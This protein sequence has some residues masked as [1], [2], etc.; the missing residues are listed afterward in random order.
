MN[1]KRRNEIEKMKADLATIKVATELLAG[2]VQDAKDAL[3]AIKDAEQDAYDNMP[4]GLQQGDRGQACEVAVSAL[5]NVVGTLETFGDALTDL[6][7]EGDLDEAT[8]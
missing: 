3:E 2:R 6:D 7:V 4:E 5:E 1:N 8:A